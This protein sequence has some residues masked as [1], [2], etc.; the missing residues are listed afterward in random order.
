MLKKNAI[1]KAIGLGIV[2][3]VALEI[4]YFFLGSI[5]GYVFSQFLPFI[6]ALLIVLI[7]LGF[8]RTII[9]ELIFGI[10]TFIT[11]H[12]L[13]LYLF[14]NI[15]ARPIYNILMLWLSSPYFWLDAILFSFAG[16]FGGFFGARKVSITSKVPSILLTEIE[17]KLLDYLTK[18]EYKIRLSDC[19]K[20]LGLT[21]EE[22]EAT[23]KSL[24]G[25]GFL[26]K[27]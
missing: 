25:K 13:I 18:H 4:I 26:K 8:L 7:A 2:F 19:A 12:L 1:L 20:E 27:V 3:G 11:W 14:S 10:A 16:F 22:V 9:G 17:G 6:W 24:Q 21:V 5:M 15:Y 23:I